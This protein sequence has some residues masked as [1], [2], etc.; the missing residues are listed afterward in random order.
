MEKQFEYFSYFHHLVSTVA[1]YGNE[2]PNFFHGNLILKTFYSDSKKTKINAKQTNDQLIETIFY[3]TNKVV[4]SLHRERYD[5]NIELEILPMSGLGDKYRLLYNRKAA[6]G[7]SDNS[8]EFL[9][10]HYR[11]ARGLAIILKEDG[12]DGLTWL[13]EKEARDM[14]AKFS[15]TNLQAK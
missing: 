9:Q 8:L 15:A 7:N 1:I 12:K 13:E 2:E 6:P 14:I 11:D 10:D 4:R 3:E 5:E